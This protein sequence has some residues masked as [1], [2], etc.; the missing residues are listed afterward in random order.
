MESERCPYSID[1][2]GSDVQAEGAHLRSLGKVVQ[3]EM[4]GG[5]PAWSVNGHELAKQVF[6]DPRFAKDPRKHWPAYIDGRI[7]DDWPLISWVKMDS[8]AINDGEE[9]KRL[10]GLISR[11]FSPR[12]IADK[13][14][15][16]EQIVA[17]LLDELAATEPGTAVDLKYFGHQVASQTVFEIFGVPQEARAEVL[18]GGAAA[19]DTTLS[20]EQ[21]AVNLMA[22]QNALG[23]VVEAK[24]GAPAEDMIS[25]LIKARDDDGRL[26]DSELIGSLFMALGA[27]SETVV[28]ML[29]MA[30][31]NLLTH[32][33]QLELVRS[34][35]VSWDEVIDEV[36][37]FEP[38]LV[39]LPLRYATEDVDLG[40]VTVPKGDAVLICLSATA[41][42]PELHGG[43]A[44]EFDITRA[45]KEHLS[46]GHGVHYCLGAPLA[47]LEANIALPA[48]F[49][50]FPALALAVAPDAL[51]P[52]GTF[53]MNGHRSLPVIL[54]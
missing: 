37:R 4:P 34:G 35:K 28:N 14:P 52:Q 54:T 41:R 11:S 12:R 38:P 49:D 21:V 27:G 18:R 19:V 51:E 2:S 36:M 43:T 40:G 23:A 25:D 8:M 32:P 9:H 46:F 22:W 24:R 39:M 17:G 10:R 5:V 16:I 7:G 29:S 1:V 3:V 53:I 50:R 44:D 20:P 48:L 47:R 13:R 33:E 45:D 30:I 31:L 42:D 26:T 15:M 6:A